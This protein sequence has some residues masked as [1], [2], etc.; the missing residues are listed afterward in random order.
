MSISPE[1]VEQHQ[2]VTPP[3]S[4]TNQPLTP[5]LTDKTPFTTALRVIALF[6]QIQAGRDTKQRPWTVFQ[7][8]PGEYDEIESTLQQDDELSRFVDAKI[9][10]DYDGYKCRLVVRMP[11]HVHERFTD[12]VEDA[13]RS[14]LKEIRNGSGRMAHFA[15]KVEPAGSSTIHFAP[16]ALSSKSKYEP[17]AEFFHDDAEYPGVIIEVSY[18]QKRKH[19]PRLAENYLLDSDAS[20]RAVVGL[21]IEY[22]KKGSRKATLSIWRPRLFVTTDGSELRVMEE[23]ADEAF[24]DDQGN[25]VDHP[26][27]R[28]HLSDFAYE[29][30]VQDE[31]GDDDMEIN[32]SGAQLCEYLT[33]AERRVQRVQSLGKHTIAREVKKR[34]RSETPPE[35]IRSGDEAWYIEQEKEHS[36]RTADQDS[37][38][39]D[40]SSTE[41]LSE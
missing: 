12:K 8:A 9:R 33:A 20:V 29:E 13:I 35:E 41:S 5:P 22:G 31:L 36:E 34:K 26:G 7:L 30:L 19:L 27:I 37:D 11:T 24:R 6:R 10:Y 25:P 21:D 17:D 1:D 39:K 23:P 32:I 38:Y 18:A 2:H 40:T 16:S 15:Q 14:Q 28:L 3:S 4:F